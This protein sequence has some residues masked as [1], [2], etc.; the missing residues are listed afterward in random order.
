MQNKEPSLE[1]YVEEKTRDGY[2]VALIGKDSIVVTPY[3]DPSDYPEMRITNK[4]FCIDEKHKGEWL[5]I[6]SGC[7]EENKNHFKQ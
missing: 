2:G 4:G 7:L 1:E 6:H 5:C 3:I